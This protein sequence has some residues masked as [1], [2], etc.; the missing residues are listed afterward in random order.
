MD[1]IFSKKI[2]NYN[3]FAKT[4]ATQLGAGISFHQ[5]NHLLRHRRRKSV[6]LR[7][8]RHKTEKLSASFFLFT[9][10]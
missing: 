9:L 3:I 5:K 6:Y 1:E 10:S 7:L 2:H 4:N 8:S